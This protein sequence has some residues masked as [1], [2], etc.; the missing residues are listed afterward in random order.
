MQN[1]KSNPNAQDAFDL[2]AKSLAAKIH[3]CIPGNII[4]YN[5]QTRLADAQPA[6]RIPLTDGRYLDRPLILGAPVLMPTSGNFGL[7]LNPQPG[8]ACLILFADTALERWRTTY[9]PTNPI[10][11]RRHDEADAIIL[12]GFS[13]QPTTPLGKI[14][15]QDQKGTIG[16]AITTNKTI[17]VT[18]PSDGTMAVGT[19]P[20]KIVDERLIEA[21]NNHTHP[22]N[23]QPPSTTINTNDVTSSKLNA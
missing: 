18:L 9:E 1:L 17:Q 20:R 6:I 15:I 22:G 16:F 5:P 3:T 7:I 19:N 13:K 11:A 23:D 12:P 4:A 2:F 21:F 14:A 8:D 10:S